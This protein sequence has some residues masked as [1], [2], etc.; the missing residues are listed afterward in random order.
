MTYSRWN[1]ASTS[2][3]PPHFMNNSVPNTTTRQIYSCPSTWNR[4][5]GSSRSGRFDCLTEPGIVHQAVAY[6]F[7]RVETDVVSMSSRR[8]P[9]SPGPRAL[10]AE[11]AAARLD[12]IP[13]QVRDDDQRRPVSFGRQL[14]S[15]AVAGLFAE[16]PC[17]YGT[18]A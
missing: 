1:Q 13:D 11:A 16:K 4:V 15:Y 17:S 7:R 18:T 8:R 5:A 2:L 14:N 12:K 10:H 3:S 9:G 6:L